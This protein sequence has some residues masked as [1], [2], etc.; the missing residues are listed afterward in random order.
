[1]K[2]YFTWSAASIFVLLITGCD[3][4]Y[5]PMGGGWNHMMNYGYGYGFGGMFMGILF[6]II[7]GV[8]AYFI[9]QSARAKTSDGT[10]QETPRDI[11]KKRYARGEI[12]KEEY[13]RMKKD[14]EG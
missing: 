14:I 9:I 1:M 8:V 5:G 10:L 6:I 13:E 3:G 4:Y 12:T 2:N 11:L 7:I